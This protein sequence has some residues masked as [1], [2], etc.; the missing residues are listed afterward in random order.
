[1]DFIKRL[2]RLAMEYQDTLDEPVSTEPDN[3]APA[4]ESPASPVQE[5][6]CVEEPAEPDEPAAPEM[7]QNCRHT[8]ATDADTHDTFIDFGPR[9]PSFFDKD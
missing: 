2:I 5:A 4:E 6:P 8:A 9:R 1:M 3:G 7:Y